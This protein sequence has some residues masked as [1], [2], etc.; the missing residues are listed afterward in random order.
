MGYYGD[1][2]MKHAVSLTASKA[3]SLLSVSVLNIMSYKWN[4]LQRAVTA[5]L[6]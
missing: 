2:C 3:E 4:I 6:S 1:S 5:H